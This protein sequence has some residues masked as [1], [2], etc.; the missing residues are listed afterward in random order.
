M[1]SDHGDPNDALINALASECGG[2]VTGFVLV[3]TF[4]DDEGDRRIWT[5]TM[6]G[7]LCHETIGLLG[8]AH[9]IEEQRAQRAW[10][11]DE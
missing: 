2:V 11:E 5:D 7:Q 10:E 8:W 6:R 3:A 9:A 4:I 1:N